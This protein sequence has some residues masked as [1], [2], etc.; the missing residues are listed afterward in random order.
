MTDESASELFARAG[1]LDAAGDER[2]A[3]PLYRAALAGGLAAPERTQAVI[4]LASSLRVDG[5]ASGAIAL[6]RSVPDDDPLAPAARAFLALAL[7]DDGKPAEALRIALHTLI[8]ALPL[9]RRS[10]T[11]YADDLT[12]SDRVRAIAVGLVVEDGW[13]LGEEYVPNGRHDGFLR[14]PGGGIEFG[15]TAAAAIRREFAEELEAD[16]DDAELLGVTESIFD[17]HGKRGH[18]IVYVFAVRSSALRRLGRTQRR[19]VLDSDTTV[20]WYPLEDVRSGAVTFH[21]RG[22][23]DLLP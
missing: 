8:P 19:A 14:A 9:Y 4:Q 21:P 6:L 1:E 13:I 23:I 15:E 22:A 7:H 10:L 17:A 2:G 12:G 20:G 18:E 11:A 5:D 16:V 3:I